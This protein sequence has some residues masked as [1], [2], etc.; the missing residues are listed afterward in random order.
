MLKNIKNI[1]PKPEN[2]SSK[3]ESKKPK[4]MFYFCISGDKPGIWIRKENALALRVD[5]T[6]A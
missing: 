2:F 6:A 1:I 5:G 4:R 3:C